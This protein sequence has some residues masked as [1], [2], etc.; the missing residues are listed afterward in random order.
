MIPRRRLIGTTLFGG[1]LG[2]ATVPPPEREDG[3]SSDPS[4]RREGS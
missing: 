4:G 3:Q 2:G 1:L